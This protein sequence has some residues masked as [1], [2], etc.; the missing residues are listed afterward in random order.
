MTILLVFVSSRTNKKGKGREE[1]KEEKKREKRRR[2]KRKRIFKK[3]EGCT[4][5]RSSAAA[6][7]RAT[8][9]ASIIS[10]DR[11][12]SFL[13]MFRVNNTTP[14]SVGWEHTTRFDDILLRAGEVPIHQVREC[15]CCVGVQA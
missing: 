5:Q 9:I 14:Y 7:R 13:G 15:V 6:A 8:R 4:L 12:F 1:K 10:P 3:I 2:M 11:L